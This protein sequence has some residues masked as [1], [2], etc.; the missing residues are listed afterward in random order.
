MKTSRRQSGTGKV[1]VKFVGVTMLIAMAGALCGASAAEGRIPFPEALAA[2]EVHLSSMSDGQTESLMVGNGD[3]YGIVWEKDGGLFMRITKNDI[4]DARVDTSKDGPMP[5]VD[6]AAGTITGPVGAPPSSENNLFPQP[7]AATALRLGPLSLAGETDDGELALE[8]PDK[9]HLD[10]RRALASIPSAGGSETQIRILHD[11]NVL[12]VKSPHPVTIDPIKADTLPDAT[13]GTTDG[14]DWLLMSMPGDIDYEGMDYA[15]AVASQGEWKAVA[16][17]TS[18][19]IDSREVLPRALALAKETLDQ[20]VAA[21]IATHESGWERYWSRSGVALQDIELQRWWYRMLYFAQTVCKPGAAPVGLMPPLATDLTPWHADFHH[22]YNAWQAFYPLPGANQSELTDPW[23]TY[24]ND[25]LPKF[26]FLAQAKYGIDGAHMEVSS[27]MHEPDPALSRSVNKRQI[28]KNPWGMTIGMGGMTLQSMW[29]RH[30]L[31]PDVAYMEAK[32]YPTLRELA[33]FYVGFMELCK[34]DDQGKILLGPSYSP[35]H[36]SFGIY[37]CPYDIAYIHYTFDAM[38]Q[39][40]GELGRDA[41][42]AAQCRRFKALLPDYP[43]TMHRG[44]EIVVDWLGGEPIREHNVTVPAV[45]V[46]P[47][48]QVTWFSPE[49]VK[50]LFRDTIEVMH[51]RDT[52]AHVMFNIAKARLSMPDGYTNGRKWFISRELP[53][54]FFRWPNCRHGTFM[55]EMIGIA[56]LINEFLLQSVDNKIR[57]FPCWPA[58]KD[59]EFT[60][61]RAQGGFLV[62][63]EQKNG[64]VV[65]LEIVSTAGGTLQVLSPWENIQVNGKK[66]VI[67]PQGLVTVPTAPGEK[68]VFEETGTG[69][70][71]PAR[72]PASQNGDAVA[73]RA[74]ETLK[75]TYSDVT[76]IGP[77]AG[78]MR[79]DP[80]DIIKVGDLYYV[81]YTK[82][83]IYSGYNGTVWYAT[84]PDGHTWTEQ[85]EAVARGAEGGWDGQSVFTPNI[86]VAEGRYWLFYSGVSFFPQDGKPDTKIG[87][88]V[89]DSPAGPW[90]KLA[91]NPVLGNSDD[92]E[93][94]D[95]MLV[96]DACLI[97]RDGEYWFYYKGRQLGK[98][99][100]QT[101]MGLAIAE[102]PGGPYVKYEGN[103]VIPGNHEVL[104]WPQ[105]EGVTALI[106]TVGPK[107][108]ARSIMYAEDG[109]HFSKTHNVVN[110]PVAGGAYR[111]EAFTESGKGELIEWGVHI[112]GI[113]RQKGVLPFIQRFELGE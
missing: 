21:L 87:I 40:A 19:D 58:D 36:G 69:V 43:T 17:V 15:V 56:G 9:A 37:N 16:L 73:I 26:K 93:Q 76:G 90:E 49:P 4:W 44:K 102:K 12:L 35:E 2:A 54:G 6:I 33:R 41:E 63:A 84:S 72:K 98:E 34:T 64:A 95:S 46:F 89:S 96:D 67:D 108:I 20:E 11:R 112:G 61:L 97:V 101:Q 80:S 52:N 70:A 104:V 7:R 27:Y 91:S 1:S 5:K 22:N 59:A 85:G 105:G 62:S 57:V 79:R 25:L 47:G 10:L 32:I 38:I 86:L 110:V 99:P 88:A 55:S 60:G 68:L 39:A 18:F 30:L 23:I 45:P 53:N 78:V 94:F 81:W 82:G 48:D 113:H 42:L 14:M 29:H 28:A 83:A 77:E 92:P 74:L 24:I 71:A 103:P 3:L 109:I 111:P 65:K 75:F 8:F 50:Q 100:S 31:D 106:G 51:H 13:L 66:L 107:H